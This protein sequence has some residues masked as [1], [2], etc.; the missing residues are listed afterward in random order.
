MVS[1]N[2]GGTLQ[3]GPP[4]LPKKETITPTIFENVDYTVGVMGGQKL[5]F[6]SQNSES[7]KKKIN[8]QNTLYGIPESQ[9]KTLDEQT[10][11][12]VRGENLIIILEKIINYLINHTHPEAPSGPISIGGSTLRDSLSTTLNSPNFIL[13]ENIRIN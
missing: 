3:F 4:T 10:F 1:A 5:Y 9:F 11:S 2:N 13:N 12:S 8:L 6:I 7:N